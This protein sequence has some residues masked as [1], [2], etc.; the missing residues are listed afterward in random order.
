MSHYTSHITHHIST[1]HTPHITFISNHYSTTPRRSS[2][3]PCHVLSPDAKNL[4]LPSNA[5]E[6]TPLVWPR[7]T[8][9]SCCEATSH[10]RT[11]LSS[12]PEKKR[13][14][15][16]RLY[17]KIFKAE[18]RFKMLNMPICNDG[19]RTLALL[20]LFDAWIF[21]LLLSLWL[22][23]PALLWLCKSMMLSLLFVLWLCF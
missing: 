10:S 23:L 6:L 3:S 4:P 5:T 14:R 9:T 15:G 13:R 12:E 1:H 7:R 11:V 18:I 2:S 20:L 8:A 17:Q 19:S 16:V 21:L 22:W